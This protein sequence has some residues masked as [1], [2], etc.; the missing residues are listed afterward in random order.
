[1]TAQ[2][3]PQ[4]PSVLARLQSSDRA[5]KLGGWILAALVAALVTGPSG[6]VTSPTHGFTSSLLRP[7]VLVFVAGGIALWAAQIG[8]EQL[9]QGTARLMSPVKLANARLFADQRVKWTTYAA[10]L[11]VALVVPHLL[12]AFWQEVL[13]DQIGVY[14]LLAI[15]LNVVVGFAGLLDLGYIAFYAIGAY[16]CA[17]WTGALPWR[18]PFHLNPFVTIIFA[19]LAAMLAGVVLG[20]PTLRL[21]GDYLAI[22]TLGFGEIIAIYANNLTSVTGGASGTRP[23]PHFSVNLLGIRYKWM[24]GNLPYYYL[25]LVF[26]VV[27][28]VMFRCLENSRIGRAWT[29]IREDEVAAEASG[30]NTYKYKLLAFAIG[31]STSGFAGVLFASKIQTVTPQGFALQQSILVL[32]FVIFG[33]MGSLP[34]AIV[35]AAVLQWAPNFLRAHFNKADL[36]IYLG[37]LLVVMM[38]YRPQGIVPSKRRAREL[39][40]SEAGIGTADAMSAPVGEEIE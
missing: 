30:V 9:V 17:Y 23:V 8:R 19:V 27:I 31:A 33:G 35:G 32:V 34:G 29:A 20:A 40:L 38:I 22:V 14:V 26:V 15:G 12:S 16:S 28:L 24:L 36:F 5:R 13:V 1:M 21:R 6:S 4:A 25:L 18:P 3:Q 2:L 7:R 39:G 11:A 37:A 10:A